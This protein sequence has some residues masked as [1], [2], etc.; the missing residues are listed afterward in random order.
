MA[1]FLSFSTAKFNAALINLSDAVLEI[2]LIPM[3]LSSLISHQLISNLFKARTSS[4]F[5]SSS[6][7][8]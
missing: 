4:E 6:L 3:P 7:P 8:E 2:G 1:K 5:T